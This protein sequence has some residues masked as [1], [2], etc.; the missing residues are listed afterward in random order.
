MRGACPDPHIASQSRLPSNNSMSILYFNARSVVP[1]HDELCMVV[2]V[3]NP[4]IVCIVETWLSADILDIEIVLL[5]YQVHRL[6]RNRHGGGVLIY[7]RDNFVANLYPSPDNLEILTLSIFNVN[8]KV[9]ISLFYRPPNSPPDILENLFLYLQS[10]NTSQFCN[11]ILIGDFNVN[12]C[13]HN[14]SYYSKLHNIFSS[15]GFSQVVTEPT[16][17]C[18]NGSTSMID[19]IAMSSP[20]LLQSCVTVPP[21]SNSDH[22]GLLLQTHWR[23]SS[24]PTDLS[25]RTIWMYK[26]ADWPRTQRLIDETNWNSLISDDIN[27][28]WDCWQQR[29]LEIMEECIPQKS[30]PN[31][32]NL[33]WL[34]KCIIQL[35]RRRN[36]LFRRA[37]RTNK[38]S[39][40]V[41]YK[42]GGLTVT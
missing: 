38:K 12:F 9:C 11:Y 42:Q 32:R 2:K 33:P 24:Q 1:K 10:L 3:N 23:Q 35:M 14:H 41:K 36:M 26:Y 4:D 5:G 31:C 28:S 29:F 17:I 37:K 34:S 20:S 8:N 39:D 19:L 7:V 22:L 25:A 13:N 27:A 21:L 40:F 16:H 18:S 15:F 30:L 6:D